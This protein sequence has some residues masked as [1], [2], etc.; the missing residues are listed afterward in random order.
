MLFKNLLTA[1]VASHDR[2][3]REYESADAQNGNGVSH[4]GTATGW[5]R[6]F[7]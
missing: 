1:S 4:P 7:F 5:L 6:F 2:H 3:M